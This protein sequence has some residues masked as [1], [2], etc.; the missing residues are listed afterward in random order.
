MASAG[1]EPTTF[2]F[3]A[4]HLNHCATAVPVIIVY[5]V[6]LACISKR[7][8]PFIF[9]LVFICKLLIIYRN[10]SMFLEIGK[11]IFQII[12]KPLSFALYCQPPSCH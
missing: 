11:I 3:V 7:K 2:Q 4:Q 6:I 12:S 1:I 10:L 8:Q 9:L 5:S